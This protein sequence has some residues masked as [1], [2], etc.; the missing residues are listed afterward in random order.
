MTTYS[1]APIFEFVGGEFAGNAQRFATYK[2][3]EGSA[4]RR[5][6]GWT[7]PVGFHVERSD[8]PV[9]YRYD[10]TDGDISL[11]PASVTS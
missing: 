4:S 7:Q 2:E 5:F 10:E 3:A 1:Y 6:A 8:D 11:N 9:N